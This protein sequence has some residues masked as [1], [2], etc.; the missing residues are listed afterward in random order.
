MFRAETY[1]SLCPVQ[2]RTHRRRSAHIIA[3][4][5]IEFRKAE[6]PD[7]AVALWE[8]DQ[9]IFGV[10]AFELA[11][12]VMLESYWIL[13]DGE[14]AGCAA[15]IHDVD[16]AEDLREDDENTPE[17]GTLYIQSTGLLEKYRGRGVGSRV[18]QWQIEYAREKGF[19][20][21]VTNCRESNTRMIE[22]NRRFGFQAIRTTPRYYG[23]GEATVVMELSLG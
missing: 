7:D 18:K 8:M 23:D 4:M 9:E 22:I 19:K 10:D 20:R 11:H 3:R 14:R 13:V 21:V 5:R 15:F 2:G 17:Q 12:W 6:L 1:Q 16:F